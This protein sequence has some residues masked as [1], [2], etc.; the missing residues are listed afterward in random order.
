MHRPALFG[1]QSAALVFGRAANGSNAVAEI[2]LMTVFSFCCVLRSDEAA[3]WP[4]RAIPVYEGKRPFFHTPRRE[5]REK[6]DKEEALSEKGNDITAAMLERNAN[7]LPAH[8]QPEQHSSLQAKLQ[9]TWH[10][11]MA[12]SPRGG[13][14]FGGQGR[15]RI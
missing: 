9:D 2:D 8:T 15:L 4:P 14:S 1:P 10:E 12:V 13:N 7:S 3:K 11:T 6:D 5:T